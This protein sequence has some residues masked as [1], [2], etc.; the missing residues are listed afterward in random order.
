MNMTDIAGI[1]ATIAFGKAHPFGDYQ[2]KKLLGRVLKA[3]GYQMLDKHLQRRSKVYLASYIFTSVGH[4]KQEEHRNGDSVIILEKQKQC[5]D[6]VRD[7]D[8][9]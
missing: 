1:N 6:Y 9:K 2:M 4:F 7:N 8:K 3:A 5:S